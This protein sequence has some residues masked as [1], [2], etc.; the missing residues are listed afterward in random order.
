M[1]TSST[2]SAASPTSS[3]PSASFFVY[4]AVSFADLEAFLLAFENL[5]FFSPATSAELPT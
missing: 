5:S 2:S 4:S 3:I 1:S